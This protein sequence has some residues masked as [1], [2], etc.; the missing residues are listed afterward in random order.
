MGFFFDLETQKGIGKQPSKTE[1]TM[2]PREYIDSL[3]PQVG[4][5]PVSTNQGYI[6]SA[7][8]SYA[9]KDVPLYGKTDYEHFRLP[10]R[11][12]GGDPRGWGG[13]DQ[14]V[15]PEDNIPI[16]ADTNIPVVGHRPVTQNRYLNAFGG[17]MGIGA[18]NLYA[19]S[20][21]AAGSVFGLETPLTYEPGLQD[22]FMN[23]AQS[24]RANIPEIPGGVSGH[25]EALQSIDNAATYVVQN[26]GQSLPWM[27]AAV[28]GA[29]LAPVVGLGTS[30][31]SVLAGSTAVLTPFHAGNN[32][33]RQAQEGKELDELE[34]FA[35]ALPQAAVDSVLSTLIL[36]HF[37]GGAA[38]QGII[39][40]LRNGVIGSAIEGAAIEGTTEAMQTMMELAAAD[41][42]LWTP[43]AWREIVEAFVAGATTGVFF[44][45]GGRVI[46]SLNVT[47]DAESFQNEM[48]AVQRANSGH[49]GMPLGMAEAGV[50]LQAEA[51]D[52][53]PY[54]P[55]QEQEFEQRRKEYGGTDAPGEEHYEEWPGGGRALRYSFMI[56]R[57][58][59]VSEY[60][61]GLIIGA[62]PP[63]GKLATDFI[64]QNGGISDITQEEVNTQWTH[65][66]TEGTR[67][68][69]IARVGEMLDQAEVFDRTMRV[70]SGFLDPGRSSV[71]IEV[72]RQGVQNRRPVSVVRVSDTQGNVAEFL[73]YKSTGN[74]AA[75]SG[76]TGGGWYPIPGW[77]QVS[78]EGEYSGYFLKTG[79]HEAY[80]F[81]E[82]Q[83][84]A[85]PGGVDKHYDSPLFQAI[86]EHMQQ[87][88]EGGHWTGTFFEDYATRGESGK[89]TDSA[90]WEPDAPEAQQYVLPWP[91]DENPNPSPLTYEEYK[92]LGEYQEITVKP[93]EGGFALEQSPEFLSD[94]RAAQKRWV[95]TGETTIVQGDDRPG[96]V[97]LPPKEDLPRG[98]TARNELPSYWEPDLL[99]TGALAYE[100]LDSRDD[101]L[102]DEYLVPT[103]DMIIYD[104]EGNELSAEQKSEERQVHEIPFPEF[105]YKISKL[106]RSRG[107]ST[108]GVGGLLNLDPE[109]QVLTSRV[110]G[111][112]VDPY[113]EEFATKWAR[114]ENLFQ[115]LAENLPEDRFDD[116]GDPMNGIHVESVPFD[117]S[118][119]GI[120]SGKKW[121]TIE[122]RANGK[123]TVAARMAGTTSSLDFDQAGG[124]EW[125]EVP[126]GKDMEITHFAAEEPTPAV[127]SVLKAI[128]DLL[129]RQIT[130]ADIQNL[131]DVSPAA[132][133]MI[134]KGFT[135]RARRH[136]AQHP[137]P[138]GRWVGGV[139]YPNNAP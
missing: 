21:A 119:M 19:S 10:S 95:E 17:G 2:P 3:K 43:E 67:Y 129:G 92:A 56:Q 65:L 133:M 1:I 69:A 114:S 51:A 53:V 137:P 74:N 101:S 61:T 25:E 80:N 4:S 132:A 23:K 110:T 85:I 63:E 107:L 106:Y 83:T 58:D 81:D 44:N 27:G 29:L 126:T 78:A 116:N 36:K 82:F 77:E 130:M 108:G 24:V 139:W 87:L 33:L 86:S 128:E 75:E 89:I 112:V 47:Q 136:P 76:K 16:P 42:P 54:T 134:H 84:R 37:G 131:Q 120:L 12:P 118:G 98:I 41:I 14:I 62:A 115:G 60:D 66:R 103:T 20:L 59:V 49:P 93:G 28:G 8:P 13:Q 104:R 127:Y 100:A 72:V 113:S 50:V 31:V 124:W 35:W 6:I 73:V 26:L 71:N 109:T 38:G 39:N 45:A 125:K 91:T 70:E 102:T 105:L 96:Q 32:L 138:A 99:S 11:K 79:E 122:Y 15:R 123:L 46:G 68:D 57:Q 55:L 97:L 5:G 22:W 90:Y 117:G 34:A 30:A 64:A 88:E 52:T 121:V 135:L 7:T 40:N 48:D 94:I 9:L 111:E 18:A